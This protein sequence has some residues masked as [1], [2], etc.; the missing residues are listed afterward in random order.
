MAGVFLDN[1]GVLEYAAAAAAASA[2][3]EELCTGGTRPLVTDHGKGQNRPLLVQ[4]LQQ[5][6]NTGQC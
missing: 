4:K 6:A 1:W 5:W 2:T 3:D